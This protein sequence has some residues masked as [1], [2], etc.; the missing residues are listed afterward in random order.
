MEVASRKRS[1]LAGKRIT[2][3]DGTKELPS[4]LNMKHKLGRLLEGYGQG[5]FSV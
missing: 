4:V 3:K 1:V 2:V 5:R